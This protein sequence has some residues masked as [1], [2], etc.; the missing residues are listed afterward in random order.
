ME[1]ADL[2]KQQETPMTHA[3]NP[4]DVATLAA[5]I[6]AD[7]HAAQKALFW[8][9]IREVIPVALL[10]VWFAFLG[11]TEDSGWPI[12]LSSLLCLVIAVVLVGSTVRQHQMEQD[13]DTTLR[14]SIHRSLSQAQ[15]RVRMYRTAGWWYVAP[16]A[17]AMGI[18]FWLAIVEDPNGANPGDA[19]AISLLLTFFIGLVWWT[20]RIASTKWQPEV[21]RF[22]AMLADF[23]EEHTNP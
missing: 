3:A 13:F 12:Y 5:S 7:H 16:L 4:G 17:V 11:A 19:I 14:G 9:T 10:G 22:E 1:L 2:W 23:D 21:E 18:L 20:R 6:K 8:L 15:H